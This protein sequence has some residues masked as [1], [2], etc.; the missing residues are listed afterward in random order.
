M[1][2]KFSVRHYKRFIKT[3][4]RNWIDERIQA[5]KD[6][7]LIAEDTPFDYT[8]T[9]YRMYQIGWRYDPVSGEEIQHNPS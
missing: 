6:A 5:L 2:P 8:S 1:E 7:D 3:M 4:G 9:I